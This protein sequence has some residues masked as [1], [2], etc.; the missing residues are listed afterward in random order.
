MHLT[1]FLQLVH[2]AAFPRMACSR[3][4]VLQTD[5]SYLV[6]HTFALQMFF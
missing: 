4:G 1:T 2:R 6:Q 5:Q 3:A